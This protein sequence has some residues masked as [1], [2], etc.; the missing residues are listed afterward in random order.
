MP[1]LKLDLKTTWI[2]LSAAIS[3]GA[4]LFQG[5]ST[6]QRLETRLNTLENWKTTVREPIAVGDRWTCSDQERFVLQ[7]RILNPKLVAPLL[8]ECER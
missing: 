7:L 1:E 8:K 4:I 3:L 2:P 5:W 6:W